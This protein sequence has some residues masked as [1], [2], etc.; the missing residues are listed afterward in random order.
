MVDFTGIPFD[1]LEKTLQDNTSAPRKVSRGGDF[2]EILVDSKGNARPDMYFMDFDQMNLLELAQEI[3]DVTS[4][5][6]CVSLLPI[7][8]HPACSFIDEWHKYIAPIN[9]SQVIAGIIR[10]DAIDKSKPPKYRAIKSYLDTLHARGV[11]VE[12]QDLGY[13]LSNVTTDKFVV[14]AQETK[15]HFFKTCSSNPI[16]R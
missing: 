9:A 16:T 11:D 5:E 13:E 14:G 10:V 15:M 8:D 2:D 4:H 1:I 6:L 7:I 12:S 3:C